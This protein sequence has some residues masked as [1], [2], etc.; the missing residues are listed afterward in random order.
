MNSS[1]LSE[2]I[3]AQKRGDARGITSICSANPF[4]LNAAFS[5]ANANDLPLLIESTCNQVNQYGGYTGQTAFDFMKAL[6]QAA[7]E[8]QF[9]SHRLLVGGDHLG[10]NPWRNET[11]ERAMEK[12]RI[13]VRDYVRAGYTKIHVD[14]SMKCADDAALLTDAAA[15]T[16]PDGPLP[17]AIIAARS[18]ELVRVAEE[19]YQEV[20]EAGPPLSYV[21]GTEVPAPGGVDDAA[22]LTEEGPPA[23]STPQATKDTITATR[24]AWLRIGLAA[25]HCRCRPARCRIRE[26]QFV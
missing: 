26:R 9:P 11:A 6:R 5:H 2:V 1:L 19:A 4:V 10:P 8:H 23:V 18:A 16:S 13:L 20:S 21:I 22:A 17:T 12:S 7:E 3:F 14:T 24:E 15:L 25:G